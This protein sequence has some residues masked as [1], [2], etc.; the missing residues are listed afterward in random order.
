MLKEKSLEGY[1]IGSELEMQEGVVSE[2]GRAVEVN[3]DKNIGLGKGLMAHKR[4]PNFKVSEAAKKEVR[5]KRKRRKKKLE[6][7]DT[8]KEK[9]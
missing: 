4:P 7:V 5:A 1:M 6:K 3:F 8:E 9:K 2:L